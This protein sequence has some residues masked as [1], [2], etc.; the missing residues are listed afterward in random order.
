MTI[1]YKLP[2]QNY[3]FFYYTNGPGNSQIVA[4]LNPGCDFKLETVEIV[5]STSMASNEPIVCKVSS[6]LDSHYNA[7]LFSY[8]IQAQSNYFWQ[9][10]QPLHLMSGDQVIFSITVSA[11]GKWGIIATGWAVKETANR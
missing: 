6:I 10:S 4:A 11:A 7:T 2:A 1:D 3:R 9:P 5:L 8:S